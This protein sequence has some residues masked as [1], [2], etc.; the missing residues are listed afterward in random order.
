M[1]VS[2]AT[3]LTYKTK[4]PNDPQTHKILKKNWGCVVIVI[5]VYKQIHTLSRLHTAGRGGEGFLTR[6]G[7]GFLHVCLRSRRPGRDA[8]SGRHIR[9]HCEH[10]PGIQS[11]C[12]QHNPC[13]VPDG[14]RPAGGFEGGVPG[15]FVYYGEGLAPLTRID[16]IGSKPHCIA[17]PLCPP[18]P[19]HSNRQNLFKLRDRNH[20]PSMTQELLKNNEK[21]IDH[22]PL[23]HVVGPSTNVLPNDTN[24]KQRLPPSLRSSN[25]WS[26]SAYLH[27]TRILDCLL[28]SMTQE[29]RQ[30]EGE[31]TDA[32]KLAS[33]GG[34]N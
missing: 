3:V 23:P 30:F 5:F 4:I 22:D 12:F 1:G 13:E 26:A 14:L 8:K 17:T 10:G 19:R 32:F 21:P 29:L 34:D 7:E 27:Q 9:E 28:P 31:K 25:Q 16:A 6:G 33:A 15:V 20:L 2:A 11:G 24:P 18:S